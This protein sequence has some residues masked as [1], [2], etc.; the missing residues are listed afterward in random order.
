V[1]PVVRADVLAEHG[2]RLVR[3]VDAVTATLTTQA[4]VE[5][6]RQVVLDGRPLEQVARDWL[7]ARGLA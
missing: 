6:H 7:T 4:L 1:V 2:T 5:L 3:T